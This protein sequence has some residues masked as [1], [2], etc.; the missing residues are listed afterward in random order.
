MDTE[1]LVNRIA[2]A[3]DAQLVV[4]MYEGLMENL[5][6][7][8]ANIDDIATLSGYVEKC[9]DVLA[10]LLATLQGNSEIAGNLRSLYL[11]INGHIT[12]GFNK[13]SRQHFVEAIQVVTPIYEGWC[14]LAANEDMPQSN[15]A[16]V[17]GLTYGKKQLNTFVNELK[18]WHKG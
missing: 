17:A 1:Y 16:I 8:E 11:F 6:A 7:C 15:P 14:Q 12:E 4:I 10:E 13:K 3:N 9:R 2:S 5:R 18:E